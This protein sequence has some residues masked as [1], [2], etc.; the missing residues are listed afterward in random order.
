MH[1]LLCIPLFILSQGG[2]LVLYKWKIETQE[3]WVT[4]S[5]QLVGGESCT[6]IQVALTWE[7]ECV[8]AKLWPLFNIKNY[9]S[10]TLKKYEKQ[11]IL[12]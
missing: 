7:H 12:E 6:E 4:S 10:R 8:I 1:Q 5:L 11:V 2:Q 9:L 3:V